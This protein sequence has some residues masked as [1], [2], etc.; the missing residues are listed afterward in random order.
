MIRGAEARARSPTSTIK[1]GNGM[2][3]IVAAGAVIAAVI[4]GIAA[5]SSAQGLI[6]DRMK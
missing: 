6:Q 4:T 2:S 3:R 5:A 1:G